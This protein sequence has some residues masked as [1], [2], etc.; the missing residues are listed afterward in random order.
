MY[1]KSMY[2]TIRLSYLRESDFTKM[3][4]DKINEVA[5]N[6]IYI[7]DTNLYI[8]DRNQDIRWEYGDLKKDLE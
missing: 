6:G 5:R 2:C 8:E 4:E 3:S 1:D 7:A